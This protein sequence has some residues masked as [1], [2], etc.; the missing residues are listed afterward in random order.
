MIACVRRLTEMPLHLDLADSASPTKRPGLFPHADQTLVLQS[1][2]DLAVRCPTG[3]VDLALMLPR[4]DPEQFV[5]L[6]LGQLHHFIPSSET[7]S[8]ARSPATWP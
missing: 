2:C 4:N 1:L 7:A 8:S 3:Q 5:F 6:S